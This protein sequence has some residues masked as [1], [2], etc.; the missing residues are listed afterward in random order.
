MQTDVINPKLQHRMIDNV[1]VYGNH[2]P[3]HIYSTNYVWCNVHVSAKAKYKICSTVKDPKAND[4]TSV[5][6]NT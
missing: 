3:N 5:Q 2:K 1:P 4:K 6:Y